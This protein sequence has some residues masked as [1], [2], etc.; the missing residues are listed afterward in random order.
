LIL[1]QAKLNAVARQSA[2]AQV[3]LDRPSVRHAQAQARAERIR[4]D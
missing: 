2:A 3:C 1:A 4:G